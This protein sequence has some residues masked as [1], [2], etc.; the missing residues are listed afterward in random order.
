MRAAALLWAVLSLAQAQEVRYWIAP[1][2]N[3]ASS[4]KSSDIELAN[5]ALQAW[6]KA[7]EG[8]LRLARTEDREQALIRILWDEGEA[9]LYGEMRPILVAGKRGAEIHVRPDLDQLGPAIAAAGKSDPLF[10]DAIV[11]LTC[12]HES[13]H[14]FGLPHT[15][16]FD[17][18]MYSFGYGG[19][20]PEYFA[21]YRRKLK[22]RDDIARNS[23][24]SEQDRRRLLLRYE[25][26]R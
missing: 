15:S 6:A 12:L 20:I 23:G 14:A 4:C 10:R 17:D 18:I 5:W 11:Y 26:N 3:T 2:S 1:C 19:D 24:M 7:S 8:R 9:G 21:R 25:P 16:A 13:G 22:S